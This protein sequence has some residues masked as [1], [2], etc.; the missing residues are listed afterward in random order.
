MIIFLIYVEKIVFKSKCRLRIKI[1]YMII[2]WLFLKY[3]NKVY[4]YCEVS[5][6]LIVGSW[7]LMLKV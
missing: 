6:Y 7:C 4:V 3:V 5:C 2:M 1:N